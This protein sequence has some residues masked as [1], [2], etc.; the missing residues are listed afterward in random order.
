MSKEKNKS[1]KKSP[2]KTL[3]QKRADKAQKRN[4]KKQESDSN[5]SE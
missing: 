4:N 5:G 3:K 2:A 1:N